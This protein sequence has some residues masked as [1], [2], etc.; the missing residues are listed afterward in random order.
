MTEERDHGG[1]IDAAIAEFGGSYDDWIDL[2]TGINPDPYPLPKIDTRYWTNLPDDLQIKGLEDAARSFWRVPDGAEIVATPGASAAIACL[3]KLIAGISVHIPKPTYNEH[4]AAFS[5]NGWASRKDAD[6]LVVVNPNN[7]DGKIWNKVDVTA[8]HCI[9]DE[10]FCDVVPDASLIELSRS[11]DHVILKSFGKFWGLAGLRLGFAICLPEFATKLRNGLG[12]W[13]VSGPACQIGTHALLD[14]QWAIETRIKLAHSSDRLDE[15]LTGAGFEIV[16]GTSLFRLVSTNNARDAFNHL[17]SNS[18]LTRI[19]P[20]SDKWIR[21]GLPNGEE[22]WAR[23]DQ[24]LKSM[25]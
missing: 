9:I 19:F 24:A 7:P 25:P 16:G 14:E 5:S 8:K 13:P 2:S 11:L 18:I 10:S 15:M 22:N 1:R 21:F 3:P 12:P 6:T 20:Y 4:A 23:I 17:A